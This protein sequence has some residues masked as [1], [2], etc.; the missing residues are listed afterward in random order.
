MDIIHLLFEFFG[1][2][3]AVVEQS[4]A[5]GIECY[6]AVHGSRIHIDITDL[7]GQILCHG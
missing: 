3:I 4:V 7:L 2:D 5:H 6:G 1:I